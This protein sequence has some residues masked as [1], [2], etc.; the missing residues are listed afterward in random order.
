MDNRA[1][2]FKGYP[3]PSR[4]N[5]VETIHI[6]PDV[7]SSLTRLPFRD[8]VFS[9]II[10]DPPWM[11]ISPS[12]WFHFRYDGWNRHTY[13]LTTHWVNK[14]F[15]RVLQPHCTLL[16][17]YQ[18]PPTTAVAPLED[19]LHKMTNFTYVLELTRDSKAGQSEAPVYWL[20]FVA[21]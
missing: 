15:H 13:A 2:Y 11:N 6:N 16:T 21:K 12:S 18:T 17:K 1:G 10:Y 5:A 19:Y 7:L 14:E 8:N 4:N 20:V 9:L 3:R